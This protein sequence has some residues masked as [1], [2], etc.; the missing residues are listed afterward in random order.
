MAEV[1]GKIVQIQ[2]AVIDCEFPPNQLPEIYEAIEIPR[3]D[4]DSLVLEVEKHIGNNRVRCVAMDAT[5]GL[6]RGLT[7]NALGAPI[8]VPVGEVALGRI[9]NVV[10]ETSTTRG[11]VVR[12][13]QDDGENFVE[14]EVWTETPKGISV[15]PG[16]VTVTL[17]TK[18]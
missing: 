2:G 4:Q 5:E 7:A 17:P 11:K 3:E 18:P 1:N 15:G 10:G 12:K 6:Q 16:P 14:I 13:W 8:T 9:F